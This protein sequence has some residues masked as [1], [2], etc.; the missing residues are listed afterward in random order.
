M[1]HFLPFDRLP[2][3]TLDSRQSQG[4]ATG[5]HSVNIWVESAGRD[6]RSWGSSCADDFRSDVIVVADKVWGN[7]FM[8]GIDFDVAAGTL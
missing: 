4:V 5:R 6:G 7:H 8:S 3:H 2:L 1:F